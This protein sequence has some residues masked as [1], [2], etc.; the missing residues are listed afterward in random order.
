[1]VLWGKRGVYKKGLRAA[2]GQT[3][4]GVP[5]KKVT[6]CAEMVT[7]LTPIPHKKMV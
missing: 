4:F 5:H 7:L 6:A 1:V 3:A 2:S